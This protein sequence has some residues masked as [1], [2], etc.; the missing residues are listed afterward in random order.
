M[1]IV[2]SLLVPPSVNLLYATVGRRRIKTRAAR[3]WHREQA[4]T[5][6]IQGPWAIA[7]RLPK[8]TK[9]DPDNRLKILVDACVASGVVSD[10][11]YCAAISVARTG[12]GPE[13]I[14]TLRGAA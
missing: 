5:R 10:D 6:K 14:V 1:T 7:V 8:A 3:R 2:V 13:A 12:D 9:G 4:G 11:R